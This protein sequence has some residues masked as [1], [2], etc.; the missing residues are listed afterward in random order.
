MRQMATNT[1]SAFLLFSFVGPSIPESGDSESFE[2]WIAAVPEDEN[3]G[4]HHVEAGDQCFH[5]ETD[6]ETRELGGVVWLKYVAKYCG[7]S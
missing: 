5:V 7:K 3:A 2:F 1:E 6:G 4:E